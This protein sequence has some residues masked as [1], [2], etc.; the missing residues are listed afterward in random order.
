M[1]SSPDAD[2]LL[3]P[4]SQAETA[5]LARGVLS[6][7]GGPANLTDVQLLLT[8]ALFH[9]MTGYA[10]EPTRVAPISAEDF[11]QGLSRRNMTFR[12]RIVQIML[13]IALSSR[14]LTATT[15]ACL[16]EFAAALAV[17]ELSR[18]AGLAW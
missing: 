15:V 12:H 7:L 16:T 5:L 14:P 11:A 9:A 2:V 4:P 3:T 1:S 17:D 10:I 6:A 13:L 8:T 18:T